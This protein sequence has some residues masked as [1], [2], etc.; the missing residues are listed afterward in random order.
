MDLSPVKREALEALLLHDKPVK[1][2]QL[3]KEMQKEFPAIQMHLIGLAKIGYVDSPQKGHYV[4][5]AVG[6][7]ALDL[8]EPTKD[9]AMAILAPASSDK[10][11][12]FYA[13]VGEPLNVYAKDLLEFCDRVSEVALDSLEFHL[14]RGDFEAWFRSLGDVELAKKTGLLKTKKMEAEEMSVKLREL[15]EFR[16]LGLAEIVGKS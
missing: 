9:E 3:A 7:K 13:G 11:F 5:S 12:H 1:A 8:P 15:V 10:A 2:A 16:C 4:I 6:K 14:R